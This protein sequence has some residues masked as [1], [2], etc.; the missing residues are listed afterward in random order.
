MRPWLPFPWVATKR[1][2]TPR[3]RPIFRT[4]RMN[5]VPF[6]V[7]SVEHKYS[8]VKPA[9]ARR[10]RGLVFLGIRREWSVATH[11]TEMHMDEL[12]REA[13][14]A[15]AE[16]LRRT[17]RP[18]E[19]NSAEAAVASHRGS[20]SPACSP[21]PAADKFIRSRPPVRYAQTVP[22]AA[23]T[24]S[25]SI[26]YSRL[27]AAAYG[28]RAPAAWLRGYQRRQCSNAKTQRST[29]RPDPDLCWLVSSQ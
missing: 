19:K 14:A 22:S 21:D 25:G 5:S 6:A 11:P 16:F 29:G 4:F 20:A 10:V 13:I 1:T 27:R 12:E 24:A 8:N 17:H 18:H 3:R 23:E 26:N 7:L 2:S 15:S 28:F 9:R